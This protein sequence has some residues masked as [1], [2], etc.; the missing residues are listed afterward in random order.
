MISDLTYISKSHYTSNQ[1]RSRSIYLS[2]LNTTG[3][4]I[5]GFYYLV[6]TLTFTQF[7]MRIVI[8]TMLIST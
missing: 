1:V 5:K 6:D 8:L 4:Y 3:L 2:D 7:V